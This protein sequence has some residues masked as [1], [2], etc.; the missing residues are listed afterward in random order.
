VETFI[1]LFSYYFIPK[2]SLTITMQLQE[3][4][5]GEI[6]NERLKCVWHDVP[7]KGLTN[8]RKAEDSF[9]APCI[10]QWTKFQLLQTSSKYESILALQYFIARPVS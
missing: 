1:Y 7:H 10:E 4:K 5:A 9:T 6:P 2:N 8:I 3:L